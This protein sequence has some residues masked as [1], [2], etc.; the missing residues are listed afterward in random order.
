MLLGVRFE[1]AKTARRLRLKVL[2]PLQ[3]SLLHLGKAT[4]IV[5]HLIAEQE[6]ADFVHAHVRTNRN[7]IPREKPAPGSASFGNKWSGVARLE[8]VG[9]GCRIHKGKQRH[10]NIYHDDECNAESAC[11]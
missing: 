5:M 8:P 4:V 9:S 10:E 7:I 1:C 11:G 2:E 6:I 3:E